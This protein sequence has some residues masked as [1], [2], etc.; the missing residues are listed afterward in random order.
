MPTIGGDINDLEVLIRR[1]RQSA[2]TVEELV[3]GVSD[4]L[5][6][7]QWIG[8]VADRFRSGWETEFVPLLRRLEEGLHDAAANL[9]HS[10]DLLTRALY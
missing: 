2:T 6:V 3:T 8:P 9:S 4:E 7:T 5:A 1:F 10:R